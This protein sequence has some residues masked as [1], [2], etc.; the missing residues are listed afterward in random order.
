M[1]DTPRYFIYARKSTEGEDRQARSIPD[2]LAELRELA[3]KENLTVVDVFT[4]QQ[5]AK[6]PGRPIFNEMLD[7][8]ERGDA[9]GILSWHPDRLSRNSMDG[10]RII[11]LV[12][13]KQ[14]RELKFSIFWF[15]PTPQGKFMLSMAFSQSKYYVDNLS[16]NIKR[17]Q[18]QKLKNG[19]WPKVAPV[20]Y[21]N[22]HALKTIY[23]DPG[24]TLFVRK[25]F[26]CTQR[27]IH[28]RQIGRGDNNAW[29]TGSPRRATARSQ[30]HR[31]LTNPIYCGIL[32]Y[33]GEQ[34]EGK[35]EPIV[36]KELF[37]AVQD[38][39][40]RK[41]KPKTPRLKPYLYRGTFRCGECGCFITSETQKGI[42]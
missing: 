31:M 6:V 3:R 18:R 30:Y 24:K 17:G 29:T 23:V 21:L 12:D 5:S 14:I 27:H 13:T 32:D 41:S 42:N 40:T 8:I 33:A 38:V 1:T 4:E 19:I 10:G 2:Q 20:G 26:N 39:V 25:A 36:S 35:H 11:H 9:S 37:D 22:D 28:D 34:Y 7:R 16:E 15:E